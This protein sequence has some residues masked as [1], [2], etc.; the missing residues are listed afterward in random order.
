M[1]YAKIHLKYLHCFC[2]EKAEK[3]IDRKAPGIQIPPN[4]LQRRNILPAT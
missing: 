2:Q 1:L 3:D 4:P